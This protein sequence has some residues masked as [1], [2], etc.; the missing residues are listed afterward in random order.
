MS[1][2]QGWILIVLVA[3]LMLDHWFTSGRWRT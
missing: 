2:T 1:E 3:L